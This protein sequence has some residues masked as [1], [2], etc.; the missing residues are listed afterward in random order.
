MNTKQTPF[1]ITGLSGFH[2]GVS[3]FMHAVLLM[4]AFLTVSAMEINGASDPDVNLAL[5]K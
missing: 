3:H 5:E 4:P 2:H 1:T